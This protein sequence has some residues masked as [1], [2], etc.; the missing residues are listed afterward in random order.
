[1]AV[2]RIQQQSATLQLIQFTD[3][4]LFADR[5][6]EMRGVNTFDSL[7]RVIEAA[8]ADHWTPDALL[9][10]GDIAQDES[11]EGYRV[12]R[13]VFEPLSLPV[14]CLPGNHDDP[15]LMTAILNRGEVSCCTSLTLGDWRFIMLNSHLSGDDGGA[16][17]EAELRRLEVVLA[18][19]GEA[20]IL[21]AVHH[22]PLAMGSAWLDGY[23]LR[24]ASDFMSVLSANRNVR[25]V[26]WGHVH[27]ASDREHAGLRMISTPSTCAQF[28]PGTEKCVMDTR[29]PGFRDLI[30]WDSGRIDTNVVWLDDWVVAARPPDS[31]QP[32]MG[33]ESG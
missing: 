8:R 18:S 10:T 26:L 15:D 22:Q 16:L 2:T 33:H 20:N 32:G 7:G 17:G 5:G 14:L 21:V 19:A 27:Q 4:H 28:T 31:R 12:F 6:G 23:G 30:L 3:P 24:D 13:E 11:R 9:I 1:M 25:A 29:P